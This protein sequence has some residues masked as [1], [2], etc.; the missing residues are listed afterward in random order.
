MRKYVLGVLLGAILVGCFYYWNQRNSEREQL[1][2]QTSLIQEQINH[3]SKLVVTEINYA[4]VFNYEDTK[5][6][7]LDLFYSK[8]KALLISNAEVQIAYDLSDL[9]VEINESLKEIRITS[10]PEPEIKVDP[11]LT[12]Y[13]IEEGILNKFTARDLNKIQ[14]SVK[15]DIKRQVQN[16]DAMKNA[17]NRLLS[18]LTQIYVL[19]NS[20]GWTLIYNE[21]PVDSLDALEVVIP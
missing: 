11:N 4:K 9:K 17:Q 13:D 19:S 21:Y 15:A 2:A 16:S 12:Y 8:K 14:R 1:I 20:L 10:I 6:Y 7:G 5:E 18:E 3:V